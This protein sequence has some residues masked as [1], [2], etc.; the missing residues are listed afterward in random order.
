MDR[1]LHNFAR[2]DRIAWTELSV[3]LAPEVATVIERLRAKLRPI[4]QRSQVVHADF[5]GNLLFADD[6]E[7]AIIDLSPYWRPASYAMALTV[8]DAMLWL[9]RFDGL[10]W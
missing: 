4:R 3:P 5:A 8:V 1:W 7:P 6:G 9:R 2:A 10:V